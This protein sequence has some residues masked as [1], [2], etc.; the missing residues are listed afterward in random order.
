MRPQVGVI[1][2]VHHAHDGDDLREEHEHQHGG[3]HGPNVLGKVRR[4]EPVT[5]EANQG[6]ERHEKDDVDVVPKLARDNGEEEAL[7]P[8]EGPLD[9]F[10]VRFLP[11]R[12]FHGAL[13]GDQ[14]RPVRGPFLRLH[15]HHVLVRVNVLRVRQLLLLFLA[16]F[17]RGPVVCCW[18]RPA[19]T[20]EVG[21]LEVADT[22]APG[23]TA[24]AAAA[25]GLDGGRVVAAAVRR[26]C[27]RRKSEQRSKNVTVWLVA[28]LYE[29]AGWES[30]LAPH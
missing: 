4:Q 2:E 24:A 8:R 28:S 5:F 22:A 14:K 10:F 30:G 1:D 17:P 11:F 13:R 27:S 21:Q 18:L 12:D 15:F 25:P 26:H 29:G 19:I 6:Q 3:A 20:A 23:S 9:D 16:F 7:V